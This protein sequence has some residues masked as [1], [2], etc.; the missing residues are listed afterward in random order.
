M[1]NVASPVP[2]GPISDG[3]APPALSDPLASAGGTRSVEVAGDAVV[4]R[5]RAMASAITIW[6][7]GASAR[8][9][10]AGLRERDV[11]AMPRDV[12]GGV[13][14][15]LGVF[16]TVAAECTRFDPSSPLM[17]A[18]SDPDRWHSLPP[19]CASAIAEAHAAYLS[20]GGRFDPRVLEDL[21]ELGYTGTL[22]FEKGAA[23]APSGRARR[24]LVPP[25]WRPRFRGRGEVHLGG[26]PVDLGGIGKGLAVRWAAE[27]LR[28][29]SDDHLVE[30][31]GDC[32][33]RGHA[34]DG[35]PWRIG[36]EDPCGG[37]APLAVLGLTDAA[38]ATSSV[39]LRRWTAGDRAV[40]HLI[41]PT[42]GL[43]GGPGMAAVTVVDGDPARAE[44]W[45][46][47]LFLAGCRAI[48][49]EAARRGIAALWVMAD[50]TVS[51]SDLMA[52]HLLWQAW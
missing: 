6:A 27:A 48:A 25:E 44:V 34:P 21:V 7:L 42:T 19:A 12:V 40:H 10:G 28:P 30:A 26:R 14:R 16:E 8:P 35:G 38:C 22:S 49:D 46:K 32:A 1:S 9:A 17:L 52:R 39:R 3:P 33:C 45:S 15:A 4:G 13:D 5:V 37:S 36:V 20:T 51:C 50:G 29:V 41:D 2:D 24:R 18:N 31:G 43:P 23:V 47:V 11:K